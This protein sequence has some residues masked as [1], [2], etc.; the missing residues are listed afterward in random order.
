MKKYFFILAVLFLCLGMA[1]CKENES[2]V[3]IPDWLSTKIQEFEKDENLLAV[4][5][6][7][8][9]K[10]KGQV[11]YYIDNPLNSCIYCEVYDRYGNKI[12]WDEEGNDVENFVATRKNEVL[13]YSISKK[14]T[15]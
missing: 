2:V 6:I 10:W 1:G 3:D 14:I 15:N 11:I 12:I 4:V 13:I 8:R 5:N 7:Y 9:C